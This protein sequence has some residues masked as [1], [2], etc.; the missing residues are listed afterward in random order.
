MAR[1]DAHLI[2]WGNIIEIGQNYN[3]LDDWVKIIEKEDRRRQGFCKYIQ[4]K[5]NRNEVE[6]NEGIKASI[7]LIKIAIWLGHYSENRAFLIDWHQSK[8]IIPKTNERGWN[9]I[10]VT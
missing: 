4:L 2:L 10:E 1:K 8:L 7:K 6:T 3:G 5:R 9:D